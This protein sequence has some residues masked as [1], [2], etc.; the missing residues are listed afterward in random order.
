MKKTHL[1]Y[2]LGG[3]VVVVLVVIGNYFAWFSS[4]P[5]FFEESPSSTNQS[6]SNPPTSPVSYT[7]ETVVENLYVPWSIVFTADNRFLVSE[8]NGT[9]RIVENNILKAEPLVRYNVSSQSEEGLMGLALDPDYSTNHRV[10]TCLAY[11]GTNGLTDKVISFQD[12]GD[13]VS[14]EKILIDNI[15]SARNHAGCR[16]LFLSD[17]TLLITTGDATDRTIAQDLKSTGGKILRLNRDGSIPVD[18][19]FPNSPVWTYGHRNSQGLAWDSDHNQLWATE[20]GPSIFDGPAGGDEVNIIEKGK[21]YGWPIIHHRQTKEGL[22]SPEM[23]FT[24]A[25]A[26]A[27]LLYYTGNLYPQFKGK[28]LMATLKGEALFEL[29]I[30]AQNP[31]DLTTF[32][33]ITDI[34]VGRIREVVQ[35]SDGSIYIATSNRDGRGTLRTNDDKIYRL[36]PQK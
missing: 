16:L 13:S 6:T 28:L 31:K 9:I 26:P 7:L 19:P 34:N 2:I 30:N 4:T 33:K 5:D 36:V 29:V 18:N 25:V 14:D 8:R 3:V 11:E 17:K 27:A 15:P 24:P 1:Y 20:H 32:K 12:N 22:I 35:G 23:E 10:Y 21:N